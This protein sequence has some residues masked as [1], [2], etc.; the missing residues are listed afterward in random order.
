MYNC[1]MC[2]HIY[3]IYIYADSTYFERIH[4]DFQMNR[5]K[6]I[7]SGQNKIGKLLGF[8]M[9]IYIGHSLNMYVYRVYTINECI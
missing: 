4:S 7:I 8:H 3:R 1:I 6:F 9:S 2:I 5:N